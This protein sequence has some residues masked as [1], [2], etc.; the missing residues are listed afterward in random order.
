MAAG[1]GVRVR[2]LPGCRVRWLPGCRVPW[3]P[4]AR[5]RRGRRGWLVEAGPRYPRTS[6]A[7]KRAGRASHDGLDGLL[8]TGWTGFGQGRGGQPAQDHSSRLTA[9]GPRPGAKGARLPATGYRLP[10]TGYRLPATG[11]RVRAGARGAGCV[12]V[13][14]AAQRRGRLDG[15]GSSSTPVGLGTP[16]GWSAPGAESRWARAR[17]RRAVL[18][19]DVDVDEAGSSTG[20]RRGRRG[21]GRGGRQDLPVRRMAGRA[22][23]TRGLRTAGPAAARVRVPL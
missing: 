10:A 8:T 16:V 17:A 23:A 20:A 2:W 5:D 14:R 18:L 13:W 11:G 22:D 12:C 4:G 19:V 7:L 21:R 1:R 3:L 6:A 15:D 9:H